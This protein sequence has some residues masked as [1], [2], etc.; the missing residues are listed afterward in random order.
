MNDQ[1]VLLLSMLVAAK[2]REYAESLA[3]LEA[4]ANNTFFIGALPQHY[5]QALVQ[6]QAISLTVLSAFPK[7]K[8]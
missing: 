4:I 1:I 3:E 7:Q 8:A 6:L 5:Q 2:V